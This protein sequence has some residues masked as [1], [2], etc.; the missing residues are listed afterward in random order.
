MGTPA[1]LVGAEISGLRTEGSG[2]PGG[3]YDAGSVPGMEAECL[4]PQGAGAQAAAGRTALSP[5]VWKTSGIAGAARQTVIKTVLNLTVRSVLE[6]I[7]GIYG[8]LFGAIY[9]CPKGV[10]MLK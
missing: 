7:W 10:V 8:G 3:A 6:N 5:C 2:S 9:Y 4:C 1:D